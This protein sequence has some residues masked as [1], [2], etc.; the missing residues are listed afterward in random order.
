MSNESKLGPNAVWLFALATLGLAIAV[1]YV[2][3]HVT[4]AITPKAMAGVYFAVFGAG[5]TAAVFLSRASVWRSVGAFAV[6]GSGIGIFYYLAII[7]PLAAAAS[8]GFGSTASSAG[9]T[10]G[11]VIGL[12]YG[13]GFA[14]DALAAGIAGSLFGAKLRNGAPSPLLQKR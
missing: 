9:A 3:P 2:L 7:R 13:V 10:I 8:E 1:T 4:T 11:G 14:I 12:V 5:A 6:A